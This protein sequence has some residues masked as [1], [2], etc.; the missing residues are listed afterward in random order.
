MKNGQKMP[1]PWGKKI[2]AHKT[3][4]QFDNNTNLSFRN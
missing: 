1:T 4:I 3:P 2:M